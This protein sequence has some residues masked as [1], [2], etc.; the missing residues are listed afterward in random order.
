LSTAGLA[1]RSPFSTRQICPTDTPAA[2]ATAAWLIIDAADLR[3]QLAAAGIDTGAPWTPLHRTAAHTGCAARACPIAENLNL[4]RTVAGEWA[5]DQ[6]LRPTLRHLLTAASLDLT[7]GK[8]MRDEL[9]AWAKQD[10]QSTAVKTMVAQVCAGD[11]AR[12]HPQAALYRLAI[13]AR[14]S[15]PELAGAVSDAVAVLWHRADLRSSILSQVA[16]WCAAADAA[17]RGAGAAAFLALAALRE[18]RTGRPE[19]LVALPDPIAASERDPLVA[20]WRAVLRVRPPLEAVVTVL[21]SWLDT[22]VANPEFLP[23]IQ[24]MFAR[25]LRPSTPDDAPLRGF[26]YLTSVLVSCS[27]RQVTDQE[28]T[29]A[30]A[31]RDAILVHA[32]T[33]RWPNSSPHICPRWLITMMGTGHHPR[34]TMRRRLRRRTPLG[35]VS[36]VAVA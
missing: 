9:L 20:G 12:I 10:Q 26:V 1:G 27:P 4:L 19:L 33:T 2:C 25:A 29:D 15:D 16:A 21:G 36:G 24:Q 18:D 32:A 31:V 22:V 8:P 5:T 35:S 17:R 34:E 28:S 7:I 11:L 13:L 23:P 6:Q 30:A 14:D 3:Q